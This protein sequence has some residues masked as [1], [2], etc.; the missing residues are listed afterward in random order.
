M[1]GALL[2]DLGKAPTTKIRKGK[3]TSYDHDKVGAELVRNF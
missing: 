2:H 1:W 3:I